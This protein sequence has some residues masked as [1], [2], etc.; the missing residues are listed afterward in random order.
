MSVPTAAQ[1]PSPAPFPKGLISSTRN[2]LGLVA[3]H[4]LVSEHWSESC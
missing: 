4:L 1:L 2:C 3:Q